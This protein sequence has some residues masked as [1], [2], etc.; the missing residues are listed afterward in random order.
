MSFRA[1]TDI[2]RWYIPDL[3]GLYD[4]IPCYRV[5]SCNLHDLG[6]VSWVRSVLYSSC[7]ALQNGRRGTVNRLSI[8]DVIFPARVSGFTQ[9]RARHG[10]G[11]APAGSAGTGGNGCPLVRRVSE[12]ANAG[13]R[14]R[15]AKNIHTNPNPNP[16]IASECG[17][18]VYAAPKKKKVVYPFSRSA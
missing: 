7:T 1:D 2:D 17:V 12:K 6:R 4:A 18:L 11:A 13:S 3:Y 8:V 16:F 9:V 14:H 15:G 10:S 5:G